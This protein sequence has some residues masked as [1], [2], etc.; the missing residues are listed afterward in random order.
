MPIQLKP[1]PFTPPGGVWRTRFAPSPTGHLHLGHALHAIWL[2]G[3]AQQLGA[4]IQYRTEDHDQQRSRPAHIQAIADELAWLG[5]AAS[6][7]LPHRQ[8]SQHPERYRAAIRQLWAQ[9]PT[10]LYACRCTR[11]MLAAANAHLPPDAEWRYPGTC[12]HTGQF[13]T[14]DALDEYLAQPADPRQP[15]A[16]PGLRL[17]L[18]DD[19]VAFDDW[20][21]GPQAQQPARACGDLLVQDRLGQ[22]TYQLAVVADDLADGINLVI[23]GQDLLHAVGRQT[24]LGRALGRTAPMLWLHHPLLTDPTGHKLSKRDA[25]RSLTAWRQAGWSAPKLLGEVAH[26]AGL[27]PTPAPL[28][29]SE[30]GR[31]FEIG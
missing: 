29:A 23:R 30:V 1:P 4:E 2:W 20:L 13:V 22:W 19:A 18:P 21:L 3:V 6:S 11:A 24:L 26:Q 5:F 10:Q 14:Q 8:Q 27:Q 17:R 16:R 25:A 7:H 31:L 9:D 15:D 12:R 28:R